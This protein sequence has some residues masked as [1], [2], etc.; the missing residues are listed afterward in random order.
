MAIKL[1]LIQKVN[2]L[3]KI[4]IISSGISILAL[5]IYVTVGITTTDVQDTL[6]S[7]R[8]LLVND[9]IN[10]GEIITGFTWD[11]NPPQK[12]DVGI[13]ASAININ[14]ECVQGGVDSSFGLSAGN[15]MKDI[16][17]RIKP[18]ADLNSDGIDISIDFKRMEESGNFLTRG[19]TFNF[20]MENGNLEIKYKLTSPNGKSYTVNE[21]TSYEIPN[22]D[23]FRNYRFIYDANKGKGEILV[24]NA[25]VWSNQ[26]VEMARLTWKT[27]DEI[28]I[29]NGMNGSGKA[30]PIFDNLVIRKTGNSSNAPMELLSFSAELQGAQVLLN[31]HTAKEMG[32]DFFKIER[33]SD[34]KTFEEIGRVKAAG[35]SK[36]LIAY[37][38]IDKTPPLGVSYY[39][40][41]LGNNSARTIWMPVIAFRLKPEMLQAAASN[42]PGISTIDQA[43]K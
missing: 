21:K 14:A 37:S 33:S 32:T 42:T 40:L 16:D 7:H 1:R 41:A 23:Q 3:Q 31:W 10:N 34:T 22:D 26:S 39:R 36:S 15:T 27:D 24:N 38:L 18:S 43:T 29:G 19:S 5:I 9:P 20:G 6:A 28:I 30:I 2:T 13:D 12:A 4:V 35:Q 17:L 8:N 25:T 11:Q